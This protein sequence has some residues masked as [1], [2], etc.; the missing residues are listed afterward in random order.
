[1]HGLLGYCCGKRVVNFYYELTAR[2]DSPNIG[3]GVMEASYRNL[4]NLGKN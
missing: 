4:E 3:F 2:C 1:M